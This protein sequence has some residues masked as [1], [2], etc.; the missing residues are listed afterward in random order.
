MPNISPIIMSAATDYYISNYLFHLLKMFESRTKSI[1][2]FCTLKN[3]I[4]L[5]RI[6][7]SLGMRNMTELLKKRNAFI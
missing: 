6:L 1:N 5:D 2:G 4:I 7:V 3:P